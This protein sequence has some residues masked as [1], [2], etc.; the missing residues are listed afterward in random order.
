VILNPNLI[1]AF[2]KFGSV[3]EG[4]TFLIFVVG[5]GGTS[6]NL[7]LPIPGTPNPAIGCPA[8]YKGNEQGIQVSFH[9]NTAGQPGPNPPP[10]IAVVNGCV[11]GRTAAGGFIL[12]VT[13]S[14]F[15]DGA[16][17][18]VGGQ[19]P[20]KVKFQN[21]DSSSNSF[22][23]LKLKGHFCNG[24]PGNI[25]VTNPGGTAGPSIPFLCSASCN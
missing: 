21:L 1:D 4:K 18:L 20:K 19:K 13:G 25:V 22:G 5:P 9:C 12:T 23:K 6:R 11:L 24:L 2:F 3:N 17:V 16:S 7:T 15:K 10:D 14:N 8:G